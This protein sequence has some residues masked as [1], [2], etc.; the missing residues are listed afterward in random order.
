MPV[1]F[2][3]ERMLGWGVGYCKRLYEVT[4]AIW[5][6]GWSMKWNKRK[7][8]HALCAWFTA[9]KVEDDHCIPIY[10]V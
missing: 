5:T 1:A 9:A 8:W 7:G 3:R 10:P 2:G 6:I 4:L